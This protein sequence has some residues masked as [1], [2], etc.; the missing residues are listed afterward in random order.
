MKTKHFFDNKTFTLTYV[1]WD[2]AT[3]DAIVIDPVLDYKMDDD[4]YSFESIT[5]VKD[6]INNEKLNLHFIIETH[7]HA[8]HLSASQILKQSFPDSKVAI[9]Q[10][11]TVV[12]E[13]FKKVFELDK[14]FPTDG[15]QFDKLVKDN[16]VLNAGSL[17]IKALH[18]PGHTPSC[19]SFLIEDSIFTGDALFMPDFGTGR[20]D[21]PE[22]DAETMYNSVQDKLY[23]LPDET[24]F[25]TGHD[26]QPGGRD[27]MF[28]STIG[29][30]K[31]NNIQLK[32]NTS[33]EEFVKFRTTRDSSLDKPK[34]LIPSIKINIDAG[35]LPETTT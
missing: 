10:E 18:T 27:L 23:S 24:R 34:L 26:Y 2:E 8:D 29:E 16:D 17:E 15:S 12:Q 28:Q 1:V 4:S 9:G 14:S 11:I 19:Y 5:K 31:K 3:K 21:F 7:A 33:K 20:C 32:G 22:G 25:Y 30:S 13:T 35:H 6:F